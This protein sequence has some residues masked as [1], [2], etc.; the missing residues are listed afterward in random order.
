M[1]REPATS[2]AKSRSSKY[3]RTMVRENEG[4]MAS[5]IVNEQAIIVELRKIP[6][7][8]WI[9]VLHFIHTLGPVQETV[10][11]KRPMTA[12]DLL[13]SGLVGMW[14]DRTDIEDSQAFARRQRQQGQTRSRES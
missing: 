7:D 3:A 6:Q 11:E 14:E 12:A 13:H 4:K 5:E 8:Q 9:E 10:P 1:N 2:L